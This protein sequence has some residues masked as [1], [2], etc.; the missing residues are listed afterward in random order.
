MAGGQQVETAQLTKA[1]KTLSEVPKHA[2]E[3]SLGAV[4]DVQLT[5][6]DFGIAHQGSFDQYKLGVLRL[7]AMAD[8][9]LKA[10][11]TFA[12]KLNA[13]GG[14]YDAYEGDAADAATGSGAQK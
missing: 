3:Q 11:D 2:L 8:S 13:A 7:A 14:Q 5:P 10:S 6:A 1:A 9:Y 4:K 12:Q